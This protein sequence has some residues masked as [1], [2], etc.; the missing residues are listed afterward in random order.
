MQTTALLCLTLILAAGQPPVLADPPVQSA[1]RPLASPSDLPTHAYV[2]Q[3]KPSDVVRDLA[4]AAALATQVEKDLLADLETYDVQDKGA[5]A[6]IHTSLYFTAL[7]RRD[8][9]SAAKHLEAVRGFQEGLGKRTAGL[10]TMPLIQAVAKPGPD[11]HAT[12]RANLSRSL[13]DLPFQEAEARLIQLLK[14]QK[15]AGK[16][17]LLASVASL[18]DAD[19]KDGKL[20]ED[21]AGTVLSVAMNL[22][23]LLPMR[24]DAVACIEALFEAHKDELG[25]AKLPQLSTT[26]IEA[27]GPFFGQALPGET[28]VRFAP[29]VLRAVSP[30]ASG[31]AFSPDGTECFLQVGDGNYGTAAMYF[32]KLVDGG[33]TP[34]EQPA[35]LA[36][37]RTSCEPVYSR[38]GN[39]LTFT[40]SQGQGATDFWT[41]TRTATG[42]SAP[43]AMP[44]PIRTAF[45]EFRG[46]VTADGTLY[47]GSECSSPGINQ[48]YKATRNPAR[49]WVVEKLGAPFNT[50]AYEG[51][52]CIAPDGRWMIFY[53]ARAGGFGRTDNY[54][55]F[56]DGKGNWSAPVNLGAAFNGPYDEFGAFLSLDGK[57]LFF[58][59][60]TAEGDETYWVAASA[61]DKLKP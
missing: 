16:E 53:S 56:N 25:K 7:V 45:N 29:A 32:T 3:G 51:D 15:G 52:P 24:E 55:S 12:Y 38:D 2:I 10:L 40:A 17:Q 14:A 50:L 21:A 11:L 43:V 9:P 27:K 22:H 4:A 31:P 20:T 47:Y 57:Q 61:I 44:S 35:F 58:N 23:I 42:W 19:T 33:W 6:S 41:V 49:E 36:G 46:S 18:L 34:L 1:K 26:R 30:W 54:V 59:R 60:H 5:L 28:P 37:F 48:V 13:A 39:T 8:F